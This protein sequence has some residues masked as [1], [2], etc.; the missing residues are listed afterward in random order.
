MKCILLY[1]NLLGQ[2]LIRLPICAKSIEKCNSVLKSHKLNIYEIL[3][4]KENNWLD[5][6]LHSSVG[7]AAVQIGFVDLLTSM[8]VLADYM[9]GYSVGEF[10]CAYADG[11]LTAEETILAADIK[12]LCPDDIDVVCHN[13]PHSST[14]TGSAE[15][16]KTFIE[17][18]RTTKIDVKILSEKRIPYHSRYI[19]TVK[20]ILLAN[21][22][23]VIPERKPRSRKWLSTSVLCN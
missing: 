4:G 12:G 11:R 6:I 21:L 9:I 23:K 3:T 13:G 1:L 16:M 22:K 17:K 20:V 8:G 14:I 7:I 15:S 5:N 2:A 10:V 18:L 19:A